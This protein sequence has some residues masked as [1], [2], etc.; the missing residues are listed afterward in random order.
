[1]T[2]ELVTYTQEFLEEA[3]K[4]VPSIVVND[5]ETERKAASMFARCEL[6]LRD[7]EAARTKFTKPTN[8]AL[9]EWNGKAKEASAPWQKLSDLLAKA[10]SGWRETETFQKLLMDR[11]QAE[12]ELQQAEVTEDMERLRGA[13]EKLDEKLELAPKTIETDTEAKIQFRSDLVIDGV[14]ES[15]LPERYWERTVNTKLIK[16]DL[17]QGLSIKGVTA[18]ETFKPSAVVRNGAV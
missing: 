6:I 11:K 7:I 4:H 12:F 10:L 1:M 3:E 14:D 2:N 8:D 18:H 16:D 15:Q 17:K 13:K 5:P 9:K